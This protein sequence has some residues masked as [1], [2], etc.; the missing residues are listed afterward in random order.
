M[1]CPPIARK[2][3]A[4]LLAAIAALAGAGALSAADSGSAKAQL[5]FGVSMARRGLWNEA[6]FRFE[7]ARR[8]EPGNVQALNNLAVAYEAVGRFDDALAAYRDALKADPN[9]RRLRQNYQRFVEFYQSFRPRAA[10]GEA[11]P[12]PPAALPELPPAPGGDA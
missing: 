8:V 12:A 4:A 9:H 2:P 5:E 11:A 7:A 6:V 3:L 10:A 1:R